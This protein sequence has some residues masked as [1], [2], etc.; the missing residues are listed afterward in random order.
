[1][2]LCFSVVRLAAC[3]KLMHNCSIARNWTLPYPRPRVNCQKKWKGTTRLC[4]RLGSN[5]KYQK[6]KCCFIGKNL[7]NKRHTSC[8]PMLWRRLSILC[9]DQRMNQECWW[10]VI[11]SPSMS[12]PGTQC[13]ESSLTCNLQQPLAGTN[14][15]WRMVEI[16]RPLHFKYVHKWGVVKLYRPMVDKGFKRFWCSHLLSLVW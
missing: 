7:K 10:V 3:D 5:K 13:L 14:P 8:G 9:L 16:E 1:M 4:R 12:E 15:N 11:N 2:D 6:N